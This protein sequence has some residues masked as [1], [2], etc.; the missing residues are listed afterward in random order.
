M[1]LPTRAKRI[2]WQ[3]DADDGIPVG[4]E[5]DTLCRLIA[6]A[7]GAAAAG[8]PKAVLQA[9]LVQARQHIDQHLASPALSPASV[10]AA[11][12]L[13]VRSLHSLFEQS[14]TSF[15]RYVLRRRLQECQAVL[16]ANRTRPVIDVAFAWGF[17]SQSSF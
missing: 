12:K 10:A 9:R 15:A 3:R 17:G 8:Q 6:I 7:C 11:L 2:H 1:R 16:L 4:N 5:T 14:G 13:S